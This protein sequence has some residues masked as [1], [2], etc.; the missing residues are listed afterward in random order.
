MHTMQ[1]YTDPEREFDPN[2]LPD[3]EVFT[4]STY[5]HDI[6]EEPF[7]PGFYWW[8]CL[9]GCLPDSEPIGPFDTEQE[10][11]DDARERSA[12]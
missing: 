3:A 9:P 7:S 5:G 11:I 6:E 2:A 4:E 8:S 12:C 10:A 1:F